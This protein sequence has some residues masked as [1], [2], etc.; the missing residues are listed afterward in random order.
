MQVNLHLPVDGD[1]WKVEADIEDSYQSFEV[2][3]GEGGRVVVFVQN[4]DQ[5]CALA[6]VAQRLALYFRRADIVRRRHA[7]CGPDCCVTGDLCTDDP[8]MVEL[9]GMV[10]A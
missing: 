6:D 1:E 9:Q 2:D 7:E 4:A 8:M 5:A 3:D 10:N